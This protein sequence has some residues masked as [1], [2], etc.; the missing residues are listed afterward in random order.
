VDGTR[1]CDRSRITGD[2]HGA[3]AARRIETIVPALRS[4][5]LD[6]EWR[7]TGE[8]W[9]GVNDDFKRVLRPEFPRV[10]IVRRAYLVTAMQNTVGHRLLAIRFALFWSDSYAIVMAH[11]SFGSCSHT[12]NA[13]NL[14][15]ARWRG[16]LLIRHHAG[17]VRRSNWIG[18]I[19]PIDVCQRRVL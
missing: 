2:Q 4:E 9:G 3:E 1:G 7:F 11:S 16:E 6:H 5:S 10:A 12:V 18:E 14:K 8:S 15:L 13:A 19:G 17:L